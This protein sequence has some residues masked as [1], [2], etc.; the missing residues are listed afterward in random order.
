MSATG[1]NRRAIASRMMSS[2]GAWPDRRR[3]GRDQRRPDPRCCG[4]C[5]SAT[6]WRSPMR[7]RRI[8]SR[9]RRA[10]AS[11]SSPRPSRVAGA[12]AVGCRDA[13]VR[14]RL[15]GAGAR[16]DRL[17][18]RRRRDRRH[19][20][21]RRRAAARCC[22]PLAVGVV[23]AA[24][25]A[26]LRVVPLL[27]WWIERALLLLGGLWFVNLINFM[28][29]IDWM[30]VAEVVPITAGARAARHAR[31]ACRLHGI[32]VALALAARCSASRRSTGRWRGSFSATS[33]ACRSGCCS[34]GC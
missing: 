4:R 14:S 23:L 29:G 11:R 7:A 13:G 26:E 8:A 3:R 25:P 2:V 19:P 12:I 6:R 18:R 17:H 21:H 9:R 31:R 30:T 32:V 33:A 5:C 22:R 16:R 15:A 24:L 34:A 1:V 27:P 20:H 28:D 10:A